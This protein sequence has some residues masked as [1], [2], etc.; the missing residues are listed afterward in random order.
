[1]AEIESSV[2]SNQGLLWFCFTVLCDWSRKLAPPSQL[3]RCKTKTNRDL[4]A[5]VFPRLRPVKCVYFE[6]S[7]APCDTYLCSDWP[8]R[9]LWFW[10]FNTQLKI[11]LLSRFLVL[12]LIYN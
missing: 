3:I 7:L 9:L 1:M 10:F 12:I 5:C 4:V 8:L 11:A 6:L 2:K